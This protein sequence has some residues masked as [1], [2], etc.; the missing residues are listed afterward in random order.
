M[1]T[2][3]NYNYGDASMSFFCPGEELLLTI[4]TPHLKIN[5]I[6]LSDIRDIWKLYKEEKT[7]QEITKKVK[8]WQK[9]WEAG[10][11]CSV[12]AVRLSESYEFIGYLGLKEKDK[13]RVKLFGHGYSEYWKTYGYE[14]TTAVTQAYVRGINAIL[15]PAIPFCLIEVE[16]EVD[17]N[18]SNQILRKLG[19]EY[20][21]EAMS[22][23]AILLWSEI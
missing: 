17:N 14:A 16:T 5:S 2:N 8:K 7:F 12:L 4:K 18:I 10:N 20:K 11:P 23:Y 9:L 1:I 15:K 6:E 3:T 21:K 19:L 22:H 13:G